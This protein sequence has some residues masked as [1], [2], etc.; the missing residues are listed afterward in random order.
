M[1]EKLD[2]GTVLQRVLD[3]YRDQAG[4][5]IPAALVV[6]VPVAILN[7]VIAE[8]GSLEAGLGAGLIGIV[9]TYWFQGMVVEATRDI[10]DGKRD[11]T[12]GSLIQSVTP[13]LVPLIGAGLLAGIGIGIGF[14]LLIVPGLFLLTIWAVLAPSIVVERKGVFDAFGRSRALVSGHGWQVFGVIVVLFLL[15]AVLG[16]IVQAIFRAITDTFAGYAISDLIVHVLIAPLSALAAAVLYFELRRLHGEPILEGAAPSVGTPDPGA[17][18]DPGAVPAPP[19]PAASPP[20]GSAPPPAA[21]SPGAPPPAAPEDK[22]PD[23]PPPGTG[24]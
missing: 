21:G 20:G 23:A 8:S 11:H 10:L 6:F 1:N 17:V 7:G 24:T 18:S 9:A 15:Q 5:L 19:P 16:G 12:L 13:V 2:L 4:L 22:P 3:V 14:I